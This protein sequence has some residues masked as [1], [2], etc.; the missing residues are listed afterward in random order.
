MNKKVL[1][2][3][4]NEYG[5]KAEAL[6]VKRSPEAKG[7]KLSIRKAKY[8]GAYYWLLYDIVFD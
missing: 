7:H 6:A 1:K 8:N 4:I 5:T 2:I 3:L